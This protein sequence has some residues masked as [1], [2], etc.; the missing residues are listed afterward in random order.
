MIVLPYHPSNMNPMVWEQFFTLLTILFAINVV[1][2]GHIHLLI[3]RKG[4]QQL[5][6]NITF[7]KLTVFLLKVYILSGENIL[8]AVYGDEGARLVHLIFRP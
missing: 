4:D 6:I 5:L 1:L 2:Y 3:T 8:A 7:R